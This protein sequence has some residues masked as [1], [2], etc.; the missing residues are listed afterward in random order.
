MGSVFSKVMVKR[1]TKKEKLIKALVKQLDHQLEETQKC[2]I[3]IQYV[4]KCNAE[5]DA[6]EL[7]RLFKIFGSS[8]ADPHASTIGVNWGSFQHTMQPQNLS[9][10][11][12]EV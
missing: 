1:Q 5:T 6:E 2:G 8:S 12:D 7:D 3:T 9:L 11:L 4:R 10:P